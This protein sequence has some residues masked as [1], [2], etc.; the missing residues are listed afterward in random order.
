MG[1]M[2]TII[3]TLHGALFAGLSIP[4]YYRRHRILG[5]TIGGIRTVFLGIS[6]V[7]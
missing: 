6:T 2:M 5:H 1:E 7:R 3:T 4:M